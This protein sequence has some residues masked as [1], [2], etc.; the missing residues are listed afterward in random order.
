MV[1]DITKGMLVALNGIKIIENH[2]LVKQEQFRFP[3][4]KGKRIKKKFQ[5]DC[6]NFKNVPDRNIYQVMNQIVCHP[7][8]AAQIRKKLQESVY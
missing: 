3:R 8:V 5:K 6:R 7:S 4:S 1:V 2:H